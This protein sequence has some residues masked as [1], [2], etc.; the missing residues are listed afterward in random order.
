MHFF[1]KKSLTPAIEARTDKSSQPQKERDDANTA[2]D[3]NANN[4]SSERR[5]S[6]IFGKKT[7][8]EKKE[9]KPS[10]SDSGPYI[11]AFDPAT[12]TTRLQ[13][14]PHWPYE[15]SYKREQEKQSSQIDHHMQ[16]PVALFNVD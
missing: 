4:I 14:N 6:S 7:S 1:R 2:L 5:R 11:F 15:D 10:I 16:V 13:Q 3:A 12:G 8:S 9:K